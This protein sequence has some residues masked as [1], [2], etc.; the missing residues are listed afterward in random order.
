MRKVILFL[1]ILIS[2]LLLNEVRAQNVK[3]SKV[4]A[5][6]I[7][8]IINPVTSEFI[9]KNINKAE[10]EHYE[11]L[12]IQLDTPGGLMDSMRIII[13][14]IINSSVPVVTYVY[15]SGSRSASAGVFIMMASDITA[16]TPGTNLGAAHPVVMGGNEPEPTPG[17]KNKGN[18]E[19]TAGKNT[20]MQK[21]ENDAAAYIRGLAREKGRNAEWAEKAVRES[22]SITASEALEKKVIEY[23]ANDPKDLLKKIHARKITK[24]KTTYVLN[25]KNAEL[26]MVKTDWRYS[27]LKIITDPNIAYIL[28]SIGFLGIYLEFS[29]PGSVMPGIA[30]FI[31]LILAFYAFQT[32]PLNFAGLALVIFGLLLIIAEVFVGSFGILAA[33]GIISLFLGSIMLIDSPFAFM[34]ISL[35]VIIPMV[36]TL[37]LFFFFVTKLAVKAVKGS[38]LTGAE[39]MK[40]TLVRA[41]SPILPSKPG[42]VDFQGEIWNAFSNEEIP[43]GEEVEI[44]DIKSLKL[45]VRKLPQEKEK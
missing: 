17:N 34:Q 3:T 42:K 41:I 6:E 37:G 21:M 40:G 10:S 13:K 15:P 39:T 28:M 45:F 23:I 36:L 26:E 22:V 32:L 12:I 5:I 9:L 44:Y 43:E 8:G 11:C 27:I 1:L 29:N 2:F 18:K 16:M 4:L 14:R 35:G 30:G 25:T 20:M 38:I 7:D 19:D 31:C 24:G 33:G